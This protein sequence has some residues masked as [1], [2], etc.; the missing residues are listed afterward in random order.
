MWTASGAL[1]D[2]ASTSISLASPYVLLGDIA[3]VNGIHNGGTLRFGPDGMLYVSLGEDGNACKSQ[4]LAQANGKL[5]RLDV[6]AMPG[7]GIGPPPIADL[8]PGDNP[9]PGTIGYEPLVYAWG[10]RN[11]YRFTID[12]PTGNVFIGD[13]GQQYYD[14]IDFIPGT[15]YT[16][17]NFGWPQY[18]GIQQIFCCGDCGLG[19]TF[20]FPIHAIFNSPESLLAVVGGPVVRPVPTSPI[21]WPASLEGDYLYFEI[22][23]G[24]LHRLRETGGAWDFAPPIPGQPTSQ[25]FGLGFPGASD[26][27]MGP[28]GALYFT[29]L[30]NQQTVLPRG[31]HR[32]RVDPAFVGVRDVAGREI[33]CAVRAT[34]NPTRAGDHVTIELRAGVPGPAR[35]EILDATGARVRTLE[36]V[37]TSSATPIVWDGRDSAGHPVF[38]G[39]YLVRA[40]SRTGEVLG[41]GKITLLR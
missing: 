32:I 24:T 20:T 5:L 36:R 37:E 6:S 25:V 9:S 12:A 11:P 19:N 22:F 1:T 8:D 2:P 30:G 10:L 29:S 15:G 26:A 38:A 13:V 33:E 23:A 16:G 35:I 14:E 31:L 17:F 7:M 3:D 39:V 34:P 40:L 27:Q 41:T 28:D 18:D 4:D 21:S